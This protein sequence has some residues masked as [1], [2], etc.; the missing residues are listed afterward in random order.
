M[1]GKL[2]WVERGR[3]PGLDGLRAIAVLLVIF[4]HIAGTRG[5]PC[6]DELSRIAGYGGIGVDIFFVLSGFLITLLLTREWTRTETISLKG[7]CLRRALRILPAYGA[8]LIAVVLLSLTDVCSLTRRDW[9]G[10]LTY[11]VNFVPHVNW[12]IGHLWSLSIEEHF[13]L[14]WPPVFLLLGFRRALLALC[15]CIVLSPLVR[16]MLRTFWCE[17]LELDICYCTFTQMDTIAVGCALALLVRNPRVQRAGLRLAEQSRW[18]GPLA[19]LALLLSILVLPSLSWSLS[20][21]ANAVLIALLVW[22]CINA[23]GI[24]SRVLNSRPVVFVG[25]L[26]YSL[27][28]WQQPFTFHWGD[29]DWISRWPVNLGLLIAAAL[30]SHF[31][32]ELPFLRL[33]ERTRYARDGVSSVIQVT[34]T[35]M[36]PE[37]GAA[38]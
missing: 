35:T 24:V 16:L 17:Q 26:S 11:T 32:I 33:K 2:Q 21:A 36:V 23:R 31:L 13:Y 5:F 9:V 20:H 6:S 29:G 1:S 18:A 34:P 22:L 7:F 27:Y 12:Y 14:L 38:L 3:I 10:A 25:V 19:V 37:V 15:G 4:S 28:L 30:A 8:Y